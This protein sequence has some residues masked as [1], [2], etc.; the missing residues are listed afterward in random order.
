MEIG[1]RVI[2]KCPA[3]KNGRR[4]EGVIK[5]VK[6]A[7]PNGRTLMILFEGNSKSTAMHEGWIQ[8][9]ID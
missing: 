8:R 2:V 1:K 4:Y 5:G 7:N 9:T 3:Y 6:R